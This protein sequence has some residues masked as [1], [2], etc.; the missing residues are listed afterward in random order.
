MNTDQNVGTNIS[1][2][3]TEIPT[4]E[5]SVKSNLLI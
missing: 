1:M 3:T 4:Q 2:M 5:L